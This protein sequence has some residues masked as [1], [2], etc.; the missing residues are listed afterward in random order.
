[1]PERIG[2]NPPGNANA[3]QAT[4]APD[5]KRLA[6]LDVDR[7]GLSLLDVA[8][9]AMTPLNIAAATPRWSPSGE[10]IV[11]GAAGSLHLVHPDGTGATDVA[12]ARAFDRRADWSP[13]SEWLIARSATRLELIELRTGRILPL[14]W[15]TGLV[16]PAFK[17][18]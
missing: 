1:M 15:A 9:G 6:Y 7:G 8:T 11:F 3:W 4:S 10:W 5:G 16:R 2:P 18:Q 13:D 12:G 17:R 14:A